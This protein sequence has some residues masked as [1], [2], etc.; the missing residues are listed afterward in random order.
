MT[1]TNIEIVRGFIEAINQNQFDRFFDFCSKDCVLHAA[2]YVGLGILTDDSTGDHVMIVGTAPGGPAQ[3]ILQPDDE[4]LRISDEE[5]TWDTFQDLKSGLW[6]QG[7]P[8]TH[9]IVTV[10]RNGREMKLD[11]VRGRVNAFDQKLSEVVDLWHHN[12]LTYWP[13]LKI[14]IQLIFEGDGLVA[15][16]AINTGTHREYKRAAMWG[17]CDIYRLLDGKI[18]ETWGLEDNFAWMKQLGYEIREPHLEP[19]V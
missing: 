12:K 5:H 7:I 3:G 13:Q 17:E 4:L 10:K 18:I 14:D 11:L 16:Y 1:K 15:V 8:G 2:P 6:G 19:A 9:L